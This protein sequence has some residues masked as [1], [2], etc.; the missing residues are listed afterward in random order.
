M[1]PSTA[2]A[3]PLQ[4]RVRLQQFGGAVGGVVNPGVNLQIALLTFF[5]VFAIACCAVLFLSRAQRGW[6]RSSLRRLTSP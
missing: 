5:V 2:C 1:R 6:R 3:I 4:S